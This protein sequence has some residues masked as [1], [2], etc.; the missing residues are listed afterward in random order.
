M[1]SDKLHGRIT[2][3]GE[4]KGCY[5]ELGKRNYLEIFEDPN[6]SPINAMIT[7]FCLE[8]DDIEALSKKLEQADVTFL[9]N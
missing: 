9:A 3:E 6:I 1:I 5:L 8:T 4:K 7:H 2:K